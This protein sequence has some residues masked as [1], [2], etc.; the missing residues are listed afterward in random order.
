MPQTLALSA[1]PPFTKN[2][3]GLNEITRSEV[4]D[5]HRAYSHVLRVLSPYE[6]LPYLNKGAEN[7]LEGVGYAKQRRTT[8]AARDMTPIQRPDSE[9]QAQPIIE[10][11]ASR[12]TAAITS[13]RW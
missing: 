9:L 2:V 4:A 12:R 13:L 1:G 6:W 10:G 11:G 8:K 3:N 5:L 7:G